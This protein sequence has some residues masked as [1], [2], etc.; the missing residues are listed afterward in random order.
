MIFLYK[1]FAEI[2]ERLNVSANYVVRANYVLSLFEKFDKKPTL[3]LDLC[4]GTGSFTKEFHNNKIDCIGVDI[5]PD[6]LNIAKEKSP[7]LFICQEAENLEL[8]GTVDGAVCMLDSVNHI[9]NKRNLKKAFSKVHLF[10]EPERLFIFDINTPYKHKEILANNAFNF[11]EE[12]FFAAWQ[13]EKEK[14][15][16]RI[17]IDIFKKSGEG[18]TRFSE[19]F[20]E[21]SY[22]V[23][24]IK[25]ILKETGFKLEGVFD[26]MSLSGPKQKS[27]RLYFVARRK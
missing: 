16:T 7:A 8:Y 10:L 5:S 15:G 25:E 19:E 14:N 20:F 17:Y 27:Q 1:H 3:L 23:K 11:D 22:S 2:Y 24:E 18:Y 6:M 26:D 4:C 21:R 13:N 9:T 12:D